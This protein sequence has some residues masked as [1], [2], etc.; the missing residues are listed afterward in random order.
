MSSKRDVNPGETVDG[1]LC[2]KNSRDNP[3]GLPFRICKRRSASCECRGGAV[4]T[5]ENML[6]PK[7]QRRL[8]L[9]YRKGS[10]GGFKEFAVRPLSSIRLTNATRKATAAH[11]HWL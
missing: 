10:A 6:S 11:I 4:M 9:A 5:P 1:V 7:A 8:L 3:T 2:V